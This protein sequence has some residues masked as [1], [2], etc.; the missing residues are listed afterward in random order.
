M[1]EFL[2]HRYNNGASS[3]SLNS[4]RSALSFFFSYTVNL[5]EDI[6]LNKLFKYFYKT[7][8]LRPKYF[9]FWPVSQLLQYLATQHP[10]SDLSLKSLTQKTLALVALSSADRGQTIHLM[11]IEN[12]TV[13]DDKISFVIFDRLKH[14]RRVIKPKVIDCIPSENPALNV[15]EYVKFY[16]E[17]T[18]AFRD[19]VSPPATRLFLSWLTKRPVTRQTLSRWL[20][21]VLSQAG[22]DTTQFSG[23]SYRG[24]SLS[25]AFHHGANIKQIIEAGSWSSV[26]TFRRHYLAPENNSEV[27]KIILQQ[28]SSS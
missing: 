23:H 3:S 12:M 20:K 11:D 15:Q 13:S 25:T 7:R 22:I 9:T 10:P 14:T 8:P 16:L 21:C 18:S 26:N 1:C 4:T 19:R 28:L 17:A 5:G 2:L 24:A 6:T 27:G